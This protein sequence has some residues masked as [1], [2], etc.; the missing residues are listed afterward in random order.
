MNR[1]DA[2]I[3]SSRKETFAVVGIEAL[4]SGIP[5]L[6]TKCSG[7]EDYINEE[8]GILVENDSVDALTDG[9]VEIIKNYKK[10][11]SKKIITDAKL[12]YSKEAVTQKYIKLYKELHSSVNIN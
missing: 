1:S 8:N 7:P 6:S 10:F 12:K 2:C 5:V 3:I 9:I 11:N 4:A